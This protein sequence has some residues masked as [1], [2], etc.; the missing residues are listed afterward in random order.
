MARNNHRNKGENNSRILT[1]GD[2][3]LE[4]VN[5][6][7]KAI[8]NINHDDR[9]KELPKR[10]PI[11]LIINSHGG[12]VYSGLGLI[13][14]IEHSETPIYTICHGAALSMA[15]V[16]FAA[17]HVRYA[18]KYAT[19]MYHEANYGLEGKV[20]YHKQE[21]KEAE[22]TDKMCDDYLLA[23]TKFTIKQFNDVRERQK[24]WYIDTVTAK[25]YGLVDEIL[26]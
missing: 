8:Y 25:K 9:D 13:D 5:N 20:I 7:I 6:V 12:D 19:F 24:E 17:G 21:V 4:E 11:K 22:R 1:L 3:E 26:E 18:S 16:V 23:K 10:E 14:V 2:I 15:M